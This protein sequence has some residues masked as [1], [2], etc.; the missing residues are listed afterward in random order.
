MDEFFHSKIFKIF[1]AIAVVLLGLFLRASM[2]QG[3]STIVTDL[4]SF[5]TTPLQKVTASIS[6][7]PTAS[8]SVIC[9]PMQFMRKISS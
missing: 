2:E 4:V 3:V 8:G 7:L 6:T 1:V 9:R 5:L